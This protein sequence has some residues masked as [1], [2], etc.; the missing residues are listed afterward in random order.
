MD[1]CKVEVEYTLRAVC[2]VRSRCLFLFVFD[3]LMRIKIS[4]SLI[5]NS[6]IL[7]PFSILIS[8]QKGWLCQSSKC[9]F[10]PFHIHHQISS[11]LLLASYCV[12]KGLPISY[13]LSCCKLYQVDTS[14][15]QTPQMGLFNCPSQTCQ[16]QVTFQLCNAMNLKCIK[17]YLTSYIQII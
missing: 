7:Y 3:S 15:T 17:V 5:S 12:V 4:N 6:L 13:P 8:L 9:G 10:F 1:L 16:Y 11:I 2:N 14:N